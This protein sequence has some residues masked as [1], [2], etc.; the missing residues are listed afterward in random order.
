MF[1]MY[2]YIERKISF[3]G[4]KLFWDTLYDR[5]AEIRGAL[6]KTCQIWLR[7]YKCAFSLFIKTKN[8]NK[9]LNITF[10]HG[11]LFCEIL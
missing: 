7:R 6:R 1:N 8:D 3:G 11:D 9:Q 10:G 2:V 4:Y 5:K